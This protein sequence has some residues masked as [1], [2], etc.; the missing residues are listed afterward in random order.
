M[1]TLAQLKYGHTAIIKSFTDT[2][3]ALKLMEMGC[4]P[5]EEISFCYSAPPGDPLAFQV[6]GY[7]LSMRKRE[8][9]TVILEET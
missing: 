6:S 3:I 5:G 9:E 4:L 1:K 8:A 2:D 7:I